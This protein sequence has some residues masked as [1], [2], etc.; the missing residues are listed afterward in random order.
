MKSG[1]NGHKIVKIGMSSVKSILNAA[2]GEKSAVR[3]KKEVKF[4]LE[5]QLREESVPRTG[6]EEPARPRDFS[7]TTRRPVTH[8]ASKSLNRGNKSLEL[9]HR[10]AFRRPG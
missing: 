10:V 1:D 3:R 7:V 4:L 5:N 8:S 9:L 6:R 2:D